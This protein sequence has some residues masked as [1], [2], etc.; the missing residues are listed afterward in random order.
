MG[1][2]ETDIVNR[3][4]IKLSP[5]GVTLWKNVR[6][7]F[8]TLD[9]KRKVRA[10]L[11]AEGASDGIG[12]TKIIIT[13]ELIGATIPVFTAIEF[14]TLTGAK[15]DEQKKYIAFVLSANGFA[16]FARSPEEAAKIIDKCEW[17]QRVIK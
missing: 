14:K 5:L 3:S 6:G 8:L 13:Q 7:L 2:A 10:G 4:M 11:L 16:G 17:L 12:F 9:G 1:V 15:S